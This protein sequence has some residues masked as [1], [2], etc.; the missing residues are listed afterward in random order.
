MQLQEGETKSVYAYLPQPEGQTYWHSVYNIRDFSLQIT[1]GTR[2]HFMPVPGPQ[3]H[4]THVE[5]RRRYGLT[6]QQFQDHVKSN[7]NFKFP[8]V[9]GVKLNLKLKITIRKS[10]L[11]IPTWLLQVSQAY[12]YFLRQHSTRQQHMEYQEQYGCTEYMHSTHASETKSENKKRQPSGDSQQEFWWW[13]GYT[14]N[15]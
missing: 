13:I 3:N 8:L 12:A 10:K 14:I 15:Q 9:M 7:S 6:C 2:P 1:H 4:V 11:A 5:E